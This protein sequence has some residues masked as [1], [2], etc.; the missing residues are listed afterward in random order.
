MVL[1]KEV[2]IITGPGRSYRSVK[3]LK[4]HSDSLQM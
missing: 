3:S 4:W 1:D 2:H